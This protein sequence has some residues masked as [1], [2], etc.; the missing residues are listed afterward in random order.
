MTIV[1]M[2]PRGLYRR[3]AALAA[4]PLSMSTDR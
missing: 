3:L 4:G 2:D 1:G